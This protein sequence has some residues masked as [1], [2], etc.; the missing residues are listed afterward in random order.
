MKY[1]LTI[2]DGRGKV[3][4]QADSELL[5]LLKLYC[6]HNVKGK[7][8]AEVIDNET[9]EVLYIVEGRGRSFPAVTY[10]VSVH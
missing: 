6:L 1:T 7:Q 3:K 4:L 5:G 9:G 8:R 2:K 10:S